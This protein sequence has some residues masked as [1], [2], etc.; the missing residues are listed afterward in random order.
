VKK[1][2]GDDPR[3]EII[4]PCIAAAFREA[5]EFLASSVNNASDKAYIQLLWL[6][7]CGFCPAV[8]TAQQKAPA[9]RLPGPDA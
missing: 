8:P 6:E 1:L 3:I 2:P 9:E 4:D 7:V 5:Q